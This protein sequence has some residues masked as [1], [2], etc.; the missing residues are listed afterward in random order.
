MD[1]TWVLEKAPAVTGALRD[2]IVAGAVVSTAT[3]GWKALNKWRDA[4]VGKRR[5]EVAEAPDPCPAD[6]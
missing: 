2:L 5:L 6:G 4:T 3:V 1:W